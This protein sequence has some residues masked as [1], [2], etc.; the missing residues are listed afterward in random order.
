MNLLEHY[1]ANVTFVEPYTEDWTDK[2]PD[3]QFVKVVLTANCYGQVET[4]QKV[5]TVDEWTKI[6]EQGYFMA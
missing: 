4:Y 2:F 6:Q 1:I 3:K 5:W